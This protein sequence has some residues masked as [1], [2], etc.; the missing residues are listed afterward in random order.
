MV[1]RLAR[2]WNG[3]AAASTSALVSDLSK[4]PSKP[5]LPIGRRTADAH[6]ASTE[7][8]C[9]AVV[10]TAVPA[11]LPACPYAATPVSPIVVDRIAHSGT[12]ES[13][14][15]YSP[16][17]VKSTLGAMTAGAPSTLFGGATCAV[18]CWPWTHM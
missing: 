3:V 5:A 16:P 4:A 17:A 7:W 6:H 12:F 13:K 10:K 8:I 14:S 15:A 11:K 1:R 18:S 2:P 9:N